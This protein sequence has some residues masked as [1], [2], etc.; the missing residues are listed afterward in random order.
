[1]TGPTR[2]KGIGALG[3][4]RLSRCVGAGFLARCWMGLGAEGL[5]ETGAGVG[6]GASGGAGG[7]VSGSCLVAGFRV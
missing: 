7:G 4:S 1:M 2:F 5:D 3:P 6:A